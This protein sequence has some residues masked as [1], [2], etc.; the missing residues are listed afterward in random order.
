MNFTVKFVFILN[1]AQI[2]YDSILPEVEVP[3]T[4]RAT[5]KLDLIENIFTLRIEASD[6]I[7]LRSTINTWLRLV[8]V[9]YEMLLLTESSS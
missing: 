1:Q 3:V 4:E 6:L 5:I 7:S 9:A 2:I 8:Q